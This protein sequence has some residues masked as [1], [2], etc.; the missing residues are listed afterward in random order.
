MMP[1]AILSYDKENHQEIRKKNRDDHL[2]YLKKFEKNLILAGP[3]LNTD[4]SPIGSIIILSLNAPNE[5]ENF[6][7]NDPYKKAG[8]FRETK[9]LNFKKVF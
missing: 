1:F 5:I 9:V 2:S 8:L 3:I 6:I 7:E 4:K